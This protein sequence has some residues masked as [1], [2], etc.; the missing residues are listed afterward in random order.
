MLTVNL[1]DIAVTN[2]ILEVPV[3]DNNVVIGVQDKSTSLLNGSIYVRNNFFRYRYSL[4]QTTIH[5]CTLLHGR[6]FSLCSIL[7]LVSAL[8]PTPAFGRRRRFSVVGGAPAKIFHQ[9]IGRNSLNEQRHRRFRQK[10]MRLSGLQKEVLA[11]YRQCLRECRK[12]P[13]VCIDWDKNE[14]N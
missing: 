5:G 1:P 12:K 7:E 10:T 6:L 8:A 9:L 11:L 13:E 14:I 3:E 4:L 2:L